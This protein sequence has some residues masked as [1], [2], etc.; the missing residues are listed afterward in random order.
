MIVLEGKFVFRY[1]SL[2]EKVRRVEENMIQDIENGNFIFG[3]Y[4]RYY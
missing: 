2:K 4:L 3:L 1:L